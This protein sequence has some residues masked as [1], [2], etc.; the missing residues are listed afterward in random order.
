MLKPTNDRSSRCSISRKPS[1]A[2][3][4][5]GSILWALKGS[6][7]WPRDGPARGQPNEPFRAQSI[8]PLRIEAHDGFLLIEHLEDLSFVGFSI[9]VDLFAGQGWAGDVLARRVADHRS[10]V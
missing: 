5:S 6:F 1:C 3:I 8:E 10:E 9:G 2:S 7:G 4:R